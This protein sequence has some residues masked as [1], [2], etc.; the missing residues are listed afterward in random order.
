MTDRK[1]VAVDSQKL[2]AMM[3]C[4]YL[5]KMRF[6]DNL[7]P[8]NA[9]DYFEKG[10]LLHHG[11]D[12][13]YNLKRYRSRWLQ[14][15]KT[16][17]DIVQ[18]CV[19]AMRH[20]ALSMNLSLGDVETVIDAFIQYTDFWENDDWRDDNII[21]VEKVYSR[22]LFESPEL[23]I[24]YEGK[25]DLIRKTGTKLVSVDH[26][27]VSS[28][29]DPNEL[30]NQFRGYCWLLDTNE[31][32]INE[33]GFQKSLKAAD[34]F[35]RHV[36]QYSQATLNEWRE[37]AIFWIRLMLGLIETDKFPMNFTSCDKYSGCQ[38][39]DMCV[40]D[41]EVREHMISQL[42]EIRTW[43]VGAQNL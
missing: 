2:D 40:R 43:D 16:Y 4:A 7:V 34:K 38:F 25:I 23:V 37:N 33:V 18:S 32:I 39:K 1:I 30:S 14:N 10:G 13:F 36:I 21:A 20:K 27:S 5:Y 19:V 12:T 3:F 31:I 29:R 22:L 26:K 11:L 24:L 15:N 41:P 42:Y 8:K 28:R 9:P 6:I 17:A 35:R